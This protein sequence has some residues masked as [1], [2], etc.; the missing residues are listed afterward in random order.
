MGNEDRSTLGNR[1]NRKRQETK[2]II[3]NIEGP[4]P[5]LLLPFKM[6]SMPMKTIPNA[7]Q[8]RV[9]AS[10]TKQS[11]WRAQLQLNAIRGVHDCF[12]HSAHVHPVGTHCPQH[13]CCCDGLLVHGP[14]VAT[15]RRGGHLWFGDHF[16]IDA[17]GEH[18]IESAT[19]AT[20]RTTVVT[21][22]EVMDYDKMNLLLLE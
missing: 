13:G 17:V 4:A 7:D 19:V 3:T 22:D 8:S 5:T 10:Q 2:I 16:L 12:A 11:V 1:Q 20:R 9:Q 18:F 14:T 6:T 15:S 21:D